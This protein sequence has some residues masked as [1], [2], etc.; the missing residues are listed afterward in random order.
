[1]ILLQFVC[2]SMTIIVQIIKYYRIYML[3]NLILKIKKVPHPG[4]EPG[5][6]E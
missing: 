4:I 2:V 5:S 3:R 1:M 6:R